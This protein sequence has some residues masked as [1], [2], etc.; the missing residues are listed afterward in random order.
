MG[1]QGV[2]ARDWW[3]WCLGGSRCVRC[4]CAVLDRWC[5]GEELYSWPKG[6]HPFCPSLDQLRPNLQGEQGGGL[7]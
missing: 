3:L 4:V 2:G 5:E 1:S 7:N 6:N